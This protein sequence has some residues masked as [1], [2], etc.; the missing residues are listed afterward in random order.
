MLKLW[1]LLDNWK[2]VLAYLLANLPGI[3]E[4]PM[5]RDAVEKVMAE[6]SAQ[7]IVNLCIQLLFVTGVLHRVMKNLR[8]QA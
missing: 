1:K 6:P 7:N 3:S 8:T 2:M 5:L 4:Y